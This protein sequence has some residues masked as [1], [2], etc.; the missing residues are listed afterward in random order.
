MKKKEHHDRYFNIDGSKKVERRDG[1]PDLPENMD[2]VRQCNEAGSKFLIDDSADNK[3]VVL[4][5][6]VGKYMDTSLIDVDIQTRIVRVL[7]KG[8][9]LCLVLPEEVKPDQ[10]VAQ[11]SKVTG[12]VGTFTHVILQPKHGSVDDTQYGLHVTNLTPGSDN[13]SHGLA[14]HHHAQGVRQAS[15][16][17]NDGDLRGG[18]GG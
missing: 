4:D 7:I 13:P 5:V 17:Q 6:Q 15:P 9:M 10:A 8:K 14:R 12:M 1:F 3:S 11:R 18:R 16:G 2:N